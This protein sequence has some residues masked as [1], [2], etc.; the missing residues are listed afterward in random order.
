VNTSDF[1]YHLPPDQIAQTPAEPRDSSRLL[2]LDRSNGEIQHRVFRD[3]GEF[4]TPGD[5]LVFNQTRVIPARLLGKKASG[6][7]AEFLLLR[8][9]APQTWRGLIGG[10]NVKLGTRLIFENGDRRI[11]AEV[12]GMGEK[13]E[14]ILRFDQPLSPL[15]ENLGEMPLPPYIHHRLSDPDRYQTVYA[16]DPGSAAA[17]TAGLH[18]T[19]DLLIQLRDRGIGMAYC[20]LHI[21]LDTFLPVREEHLE[22][23]PM[24]SEQALLR[25]EDAR[26]INEAI[27]AGSRIIAV[28]TTSVR[29]L[30]SAALHS[31]GIDDP[32]AP[33]ADACAWKPVSAFDAP[34][35]LFIRP[36][37][38]F[39]IVSGMITNFHLPRSTLLAL[40]SAFAGREKL[41][42]AYALAQ[43]EGYRF[44]S[45]GDAML[46]L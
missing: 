42:D 25:P 18:F 36:G 44:Y 32:Y 9:E 24:H 4:L 15:L 45:F 23:H 7:K 28:G 43:R 12:V 13:S 2:V 27:L 3:I 21:G 34:T 31:A 20:T 40:V 1:D 6:G 35:R 5:V 19:P 33:G 16:R 8:R 14:R 30:E 29:T 46:I 22:D 17:P 37:Y 41:L 39:R 11:E 10:H 38:G 26:L